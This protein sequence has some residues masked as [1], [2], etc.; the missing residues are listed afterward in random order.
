MADLDHGDLGPNMLAATFTTWGIALIF[1]LMRF[2]TRATIVRKLGLSD[3]FIALSLVW[4]FQTR[5]SWAQTDNEQ[6]RSPQGGCA[7][8]Y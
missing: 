4:R 7:S 3:W 8:A 5:Y 6:H 2:W 1:V